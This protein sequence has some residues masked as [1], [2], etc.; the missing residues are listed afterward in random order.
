MAH[1][2][3]LEKLAELTRINKK[4]KKESVKDRKA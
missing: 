1:S 2:T 3:R 4:E